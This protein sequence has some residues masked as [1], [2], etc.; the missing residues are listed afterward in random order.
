MGSWSGE[1]SALVEHRGDVLVGCATLLTCDAQS[2]EELARDAIVRVYSRRGARSSHLSSHDGQ[3]SLVTGD[4]LGAFEGLVRR[5]IVARFLRSAE[6]RGEPVT[7]DPVPTDPS[8]PLLVALGELSARGRTC[9]VLH[10]Y[11][12]L[13]VGEVAA[14]V[15]AGEDVVRQDLLDTERVLGPVVVHALL[16]RA[17]RDG[18]D[19]TDATDDDAGPLDGRESEQ[20]AALVDRVRRR[21]RSRSRRVAAATVAAVVVVGLV[22]AAPSI[23]GGATPAPSPSPSAAGPVLGSGVPGVE[24]L[25]G[26]DLGPARKAVIDAGWRIGVAD[27]ATTIA[28]NSPWTG[29]LTEG[30]ADGVDPKTVDDSVSFDRVA[31]VL[32]QGGRVAAVGTDTLSDG[33]YVSLARSTTGTST[34]VHTT[35]EAC[36]TDTL[37][38]GDYTAY[39]LELQDPDSADEAGTTGAQLVERMS[40][41]VPLTVRAAN[42]VAAG[43]YRPPWLDDTNLACGMSSDDATAAMPTG[44]FD[45]NSSDTDSGTESKVEYDLF[46][47]GDA[48]AAVTLDTH[49]SLAWIDPRTRTVVSFGADDTA[50]RE[51]VT[52]KS[53][54]THS[55]T[56]NYSETTDYCAPGAA[57][58][59]TQHVPAGVYEVLAY[60]RA[61]TSARKTVWIVGMAIQLRVL[62]DGSVSDD[63]GPGSA[64]GLAQKGYRPSWVRGTSWRCGMSYDAFTGP[65][66]APNRAPVMVDGTT[67][68]DQGS[69]G[70]LLAPA[71]G[72]GRHV[73][74]PSHGAVAW[75]P[76]VGGQLGPLVSFGA[77]PG[78][79]LHVTVTVDETTV[80]ASLTTTD[81]CAP[82]GGAYPTSLPAGLYWIVPYTWVED[83]HGTRFWVQSLGAEQ[84]DVKAD[85][86]V[87]GD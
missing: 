57:G 25:C 75:F 58:T 60:T 83:A 22:V 33:D 78:K 64:E 65:P 67:E 41:A 8:D 3:V 69:M 48:R 71:P 31:L 27:A 81:S 77:S 19:E 49:L 29:T 80:P 10:R 63:L 7:T 24:G 79:S 32:E 15:G 40:N 86:S 26:Q 62:A 66:D 54:K 45:V 21:R 4:D 59:F 11:A 9:V 12:G 87:V 47:S 74:V 46:N 50:H 73:E 13:D 23:G 1:L 51:A 56:A 18:V 34:A 53:H 42:T 39:A 82:D 5:E 85:G 55:V 20:V 28:A 6:Q 38:P 30:L 52:I 43:Q 35:L 2:G 14:E 16:E 36:T 70:L 76:D 17:R 68:D 84:V 72:K 61:V 44:N 37:I